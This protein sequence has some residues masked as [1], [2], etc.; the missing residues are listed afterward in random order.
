MF[1]VLCMTIFGPLLSLFFVVFLLIGANMIS[2][3]SPEIEPFALAYAFVLAISTV[4]GLV[5][6]VA[7]WKVQPG[8]VG[9]AKKYLLYGAIPSVLIL[10]FLPYVFLTPAERGANEGASSV[11]W[12]VIFVGWFF[13]W[14]SYL[15]K[16]RRVAAT[17][18]QG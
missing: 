7:L 4:W 8:A 6:G 2:K 15:T 17:Y 10:N 16:S 9:R 11:I 1:L 14:H 12:I 18:P 5:S 13:A 3:T